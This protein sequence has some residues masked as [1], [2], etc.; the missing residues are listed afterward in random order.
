MII[1]VTTGNGRV[2]LPLELPATDAEVRK[3]ESVLETE[4][5]CGH[6]QVVSVECPVSSLGKYI[7]G[8]YVSNPGVRKNLNTL[9]EKINAMNTLD[10]KTCT[11]AL[12]LA[13]MNGLDDVLRVVD[14]LNEYIFIHSVTTKE[15]LGRFLVD[16]GYKGF[17]ENA[18]PYLDYNA[19]GAEYH[20]EHD[21]V[22][23]VDGYTIR[24]SAAEPL[25]AEREQTTGIRVYLKTGGMRS[26]GH[27]P[28]VLTL[29]ATSA[30]IH[31]AKGALNIED[32]E[33]AAIV[34]IE[35][36]EKLLLENV[37]REE[38]D[39]GLLNEIAE[40]YAAVVKEQEARK[41]RPALA[42]ERPATLEGTLDVLNG[43]GDYEV[44]LCSAEEYG[45]DILRDVSG[46]EG[47]VDM[48][49]GF[50]DWKAFGE[51]IMEAGGFMQ[52]EYGPVRRADD[53]APK[54]T[55]GAQTMQSPF[56]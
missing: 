23:T 30:D 5:G 4:C 12:D 1:K 33:E 26:L 35:S 40:S 41:L 17:P 54:Q 24:R 7:V 8:K 46:D 13:P 34:K 28:F 53:P 25:V 32:F 14:S 15:E 56:L 43:L 51:H 47:I 39:I 22:F 6:F 20:A 11:G 31:Y 29:P 49:D 36:P 27:D 42:M 16:S 55:M 38:L 44:I 45:R 52:T 18:R 3:V 10:V 37:P 19:I 21:G 9:A 48:V 2:N 50:I